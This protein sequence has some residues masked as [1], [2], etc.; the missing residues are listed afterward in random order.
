MIVF[1]NFLF[2]NL[3]DVEAVTLKVSLKGSFLSLWTPCTAWLVYEFMHVTR[4]KNK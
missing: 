3:T 1:L 2:F 4:W